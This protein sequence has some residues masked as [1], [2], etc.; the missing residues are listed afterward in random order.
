MRL[1]DWIHLIVTLDRFG[2]RIGQGVELR[3]DPHGLAR[4][5]VT[6]NE[7]RFVICIPLLRNYDSALS[8]ALVEKITYMPFPEDA[9]EP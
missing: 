6:T 5:E 7:A 4:I 9:A 2:N 1:V 3:V 8:D